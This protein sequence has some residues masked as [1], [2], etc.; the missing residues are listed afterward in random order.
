M[1]YSRIAIIVLLGMPA[2]VAKI[3]GFA[4]LRTDF[5]DLAAVFADKHGSV[6][7]AKRL[8]PFG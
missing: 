8:S 4:G 6:A 7:S 5:G 2:I 1:S 3:T